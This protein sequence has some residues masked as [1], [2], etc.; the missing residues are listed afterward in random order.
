[1][2]EILHVLNGVRHSHSRVGWDREP[3]SRRMHGSYCEW[4]TGEVCV[5][6]RVICQVHTGSALNPGIGGKETGV[7]DND[8]FAAH[9]WR[10]LK[11]IGSEGAEVTCGNS[12]TATTT[13]TTT[14]STAT[15]TT[16]DYNHNTKKRHHMFG[17]GCVIS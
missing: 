14:T 10:I 8:D 6:S 12:T 17:N 15:I 1:M 3:W 11:C 13:T 4:S 5:A 2:R 7:D 9:D 16:R